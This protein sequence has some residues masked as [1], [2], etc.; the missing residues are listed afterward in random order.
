M[1]NIIVYTFRTFP[2]IEKL[3]EIFGE[4]FVFGKLKEDLKKFTKIIETKKPKYILGVAKGKSVS[5]LE[6]YAINK[7][8]KTGKIDKDGLEQI[9]L[10][11]PKELEKDFKIST[12]QTSSFCNW[13]MYKIG[14][15]LLENKLKTKL[16]FVH[17][18]I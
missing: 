13:T 14:S 18:L 16:I 15:Y 5:Q 1:S 4:V 9:E 2:E 8:G 6:K 12:K 17:K 7:F 10:Y 3:R 11:I